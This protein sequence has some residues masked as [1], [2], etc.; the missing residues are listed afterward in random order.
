MNTTILE[1]YQNLFSSAEPNGLTNVIEVIPHVVT[2]NM[3]VQLDREFTIE[4][5]EVA[6][7]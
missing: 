5:V 7:K 3:N 6:I 1:F 4:D 2:P